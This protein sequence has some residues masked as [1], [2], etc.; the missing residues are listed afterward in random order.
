MTFMTLVPTTKTSWRTGRRLLAS[1]HSLRH[2]IEPVMPI[3]PRRSPY[4]WVTAISKLVAGDSYCDWAAWFKGHYQQLDKRPFDNDDYVIKHAALIRKLKP[5]LIAAGY[6]VTVENQNHFSLQLPHITL[7]GKPDFVAI[8][9]GSGLIIDAKT[10]M[11]K[12]SHFAQ[13]KLYMWALPQLP[14]YAGIKF[15]GQVAYENHNKFILHQELDAAFV[16]EIEKLLAMVA[17]DPQP[18]TCVSATECKWC[19]I[20]SEYCKDR[21]DE[22]KEA[23]EKEEEEFPF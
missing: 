1:I 22:P 20:T 11:P 5:D 6:A 4:I 17:G 8:K 9:D 7:G 13:V 12:A 19:E 18:D 2:P 23:V 16:G 21:I 10:G 3:V 15:D 14:K